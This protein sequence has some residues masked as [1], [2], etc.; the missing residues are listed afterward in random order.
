M[1]RLIVL[2]IS[3]LSF[4]ASASN[5]AFGTLKGIKVYGQNSNKVTKLYFS[6]DAILQHVE[7]CKGVAHMTH[8]LHSPDLLN[9]MMSLAIAAYMSGKKVRAWSTADTCEL[10]FLALQETSF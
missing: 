1:K 6:D 10:D 2:L 4:S 8:S 9:Q 7:G 3:L 5:L